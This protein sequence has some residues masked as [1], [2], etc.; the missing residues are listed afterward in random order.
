[1]ASDFQL[2]IASLPVAVAPWMVISFFPSFELWVILACST[3]VLF[4]IAVFGSG[5]K[6]NVDLSLRLLLWG[7][8]SAVALYGLF[9]LGF[10]LTKSNVVISAAVNYIYVLRWDEPA[11][12]IA[13]LMVFPLGIGEE[14]YWRGL[15]QRTFSN[16][17]GTYLGV[18]LASIAYSLIHLPT[19]NVPLELAALIGGLVWGSL[20]VFTKS[21]SSSIVSHIIWSIMIFILFPLH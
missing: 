14:L 2:A 11:L 9:Y 3:L 6:I 18:G 17:F 4:V 10:Q 7:I 12:I 19:F 8:L 1:L 20:Y 16:R 15:I 5:A 13:L 21:L